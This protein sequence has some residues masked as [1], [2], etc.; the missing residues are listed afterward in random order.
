[1]LSAAILLIYGLWLSSAFGVFFTSILSRFYSINKSPGF[2]LQVI[3]GWILLAWGISFAHFFL[4]I[5]FKIKLVAFIFSIFIS[6]KN[7]SEFY[8][9]VISIKQLKTTDKICGALL[10]LI[11]VLSVSNKPGIGDIA[12]YHLQ[13]IRW[14]E[15]Y[16]LI[17]GIGNYNRPL[18]NNNWW[19]HLHTLMGWRNGDLGIYT[20]NAQLFLIV[21]WY[22]YKYIKQFSSYGV[23]VVLMFVLMTSKTAFIGSVTPDIAITFLLFVSFLQLVKSS[24]ENAILLIFFVSLF[25]LTIKLNSIVLFGAVFI[26]LFYKWIQ[27]RNTLSFFRI[28]IFAGIYIIPWLIGNY[29]RSGWLCYPINSVDLFQA[30]WK[31]PKDILIYERFSIIQWAKFPNHPVYETAKLNIN[32]WLPHWFGSYD[33]FNQLLICLLPI[34]TLI[35]LLRLKKMSFI[36]QVVF[37]YSLIGIV[38]CFSNGPH[39]RYAF[40]YIIPVFALPF[41]HFQI[42]Q[43]K[44][45]IFIGFLLSTLLVLPTSIKR[46]LTDSK[47]LLIAPP[48]PNSS[49]DSSLN[50][51]EIIKITHQANTCWDKFACSYYVVEGCELRDSIIK[52]GFRV[53][54]VNLK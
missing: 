51:S 26:L 29:I 54:Q 10:F 16:P 49:L 9:Y 39:I 38:F 34:F 19:F 50:N 1:M 42:K 8:S 30:D 2:S 14:S 15:M 52:H 13:A 3:F 23:F 32:E 11:S 28:F 18:A 53:A 24:E 43:M 47:Y 37:A 44:K 6:W 5:D 40:G 17:P 4:P 33:R 21:A 35:G 48:Y 45:W 20:L 27:T 36:E 25:A 41:M 31:I 46:L 7:K 12:D 22:I